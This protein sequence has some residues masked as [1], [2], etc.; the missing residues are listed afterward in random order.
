[1]AFKEYENPDE[2]KRVQDCSTLLLEELD[3]VCEALG[4]RYV[5]WAGTALG[6]VRHEGFIPWDDDVDVALTR[7]EYE[8]F[9][10]EAPAMLG[11]DFKLESARNEE[12]ITTPAAYLSL[13]GTL[14]IPDFFKDSRYKKPLS[15]DVIPIDKVSNDEKVLRRQLRGTWIWCR[16]LYLRATAKPYVPFDGWRKALVYAASFC[17]HWGMRAVGITPRFAQERWERAAR[18]AENENVSVYADFSDKAPLDW[19]ATIDDLY[20]A[21]DAKFGNSTVKLANQYDALLSKNYG[22][23]REL[24]PVEQRK[25]HYP[26]ELDFGKFS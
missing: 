21:I 25:N 6:A 22:D 20:P 18:L 15:I 10:L 11:D 14:C 4:I 13:K 2:L 19:S 5:V 3:R 17:A 1:M 23:Y 8:R 24:P 26:F 9:L 7:E 12:Y 16:L